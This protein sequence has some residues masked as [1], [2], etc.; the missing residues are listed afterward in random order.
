M[1]RRRRRNAK[2]ADRI[3]MSK[4]W[5]TNTQVKKKKCDR[6]EIEEEVEIIEKR[7]VE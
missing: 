5:Q 2:A 1:L 6:N 3:L 7:G 4:F